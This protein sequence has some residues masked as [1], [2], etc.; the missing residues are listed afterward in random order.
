[1]VALTIFPFAKVKSSSPCVALV[2]F[3]PG[4][5]AINETCPVAVP[6]FAATLT[7]TTTFSAEP[8]VIPVVGE[9]VSV[10][11]VGTVDTLPHFVAKLF[12]LIVPKPVA[13][14]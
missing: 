11:V 1:V 6:L 4:N 2:P 8:W 12:A 5:V 13:M 3:G 7:F 10:V 9:S 14:S